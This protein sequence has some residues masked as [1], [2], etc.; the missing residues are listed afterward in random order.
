MQE[1]QQQFAGQREMMADFLQIYYEV[2]QEQP[3]HPET[4]P[5]PGQ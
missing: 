3:P 1:K 2:M 4:A 5:E